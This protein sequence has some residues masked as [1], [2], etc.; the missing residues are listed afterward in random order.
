M[1]TFSYLPDP[2]PREQR[3]PRVRV[4]QFGDGYQQRVADGINT[5]PKNWSLAFTKRGQTEADGIMDFLD[6]RAGIEA[7]DWTSPAGVAGKYICSEYERT[8]GQGQLYNITATFIQV[9]EQ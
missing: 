1:A 8:I 6:A 5:N 7:F 4:A 2:G 9:F 3:K